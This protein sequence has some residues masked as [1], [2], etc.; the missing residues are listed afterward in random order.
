MPC[1]ARFVQHENQSDPSMIVDGFMCHL[2]PA[3][4]ERDAMKRVAVILLV[5]LAAMMCG[6]SASGSQAASGSA[7]SAQPS[8]AG[9]VVADGL[10]AIHVEGQT[11]LPGNFYLRSCT[12]ATSSCSMAKAA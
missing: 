12:A 10:P 3:T 5:V 11:D 6:C 8:S 2:Y 7:A 4:T 1:G 9:R